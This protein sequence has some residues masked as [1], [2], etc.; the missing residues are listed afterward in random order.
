M[1]KRYSANVFIFLLA[2]LCLVG[3]CSNATLAN[4]DPTHHST[5]ESF[6]K[7]G[8]DY[9]WSV[10]QDEFD[11]R[12]FDTPADR[13]EYWQLVDIVIR[14]GSIYA[15]PFKKSDFGLTELYPKLLDLDSDPPLYVQY[16]YESSQSQLGFDSPD[17]NYLEHAQS[18]A[19]IA[20]RMR[21]S[22]YP[23]YIEGATWVRAAEFFRD[24]GLQDSEE[25]MN[26]REQGLERLIEAASLEEIKP[27]Y[28]EFVA[29]RLSR[30][31]WRY[32]AFTENDKELY[33]RLLAENKLADP[34]IAHYA[35]GNLWSDRG[36][37]ARGDGWARDVSEEQWDLYYKYLAKARGH[38]TL[39]WKAH[40]NWPESAA[41]LITDTMGV[42]FHPDRDE[43]FWF[44][45]AVK[46]R[47][48]IPLAYTRYAYALSPRWGGS[49]GE[50]YELMDSVITLSNEQDHMGYILLEL[51][52]TVTMEIRDRHE[53]LLDEKYLS[54]ATKLMQDE[55]DSQL[56][57]KNKW[58][59]RRALRSVA[60][61]QFLLGDYAESAKFL[62]AGGGMTNQLYDPWQEDKRF[63]LYSSLLATPASDKV[64]DGLR[65]QDEKDSKAELKALKAACRQLEKQTSSIHPE[66]I[67]DPLTIVEDIVDR[68]DPPKPMFSSVGGV[69]RMVSVAALVVL[70]GVWLALRFLRKPCQ[71]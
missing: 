2:Q 43:E 66:I 12:T 55:M 67:G 40:P 9:L 38:L 35:Y 47:I 57:Y 33:C 22:D 45:E 63:H 7:S 25:A 24:A 58:Q 26:A 50:M 61:G 52:A 18:L 70:I 46:A 65:A 3:V 30:F 20:Q 34:W 48:D 5:E 68:L 56:P 37:K 10:I 51:M 19:N 62:K 69:I 54:V 14:T 8:Y 1:R 42:Q 17:E 13:D 39:A 4:D 23:A 36:W 31:G 44:N 29:V 71:E 41:K 28:K 60:M 53:V 59:Y 11:A 21:E 16:R 15:Q 27:V 49:I 32:T 64:I 6:R